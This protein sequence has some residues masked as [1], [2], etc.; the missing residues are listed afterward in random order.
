MIRTYYVFLFP[1]LAYIFRFNDI[2]PAIT[3]N[4]TYFSIPLAAFLGFRFGWQGVLVTGL[5][6]LLLPFGV[7]IESGVAHL[8]P[9]LHIY[10]TAVLVAWVFSHHGVSDTVKK[11][12]S[13]PLVFVLALLL[14]PLYMRPLT[15]GVGEDTV[16]SFSVDLI[17]V[18][19]FLV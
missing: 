11:W 17:L 12:L 6:G 7:K 16:V 1:I 15:F 9:A 13:A 4:L 5:G 10:I 2:A 3:V 19:Y 14:L 8:A 18:L